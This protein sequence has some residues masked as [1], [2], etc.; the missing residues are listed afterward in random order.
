MSSEMNDPLLEK[1]RGGHDESKE[2]VHGRAAVEQTPEEQ[3][4]L[5]NEEMERF[6]DEE[7]F[8][9]D[10]EAP[11]MT[12]QATETVGNDFII[13]F[14]QSAVPPRLRVHLQRPREVNDH[15]I[16]RHLPEHIASIGAL[17]EPQHGRP[18]S[19]QITF[20]GEIPNQAAAEPGSDACPPAIRGSTSSQPGSACADVAA[21]TS[22]SA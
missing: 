9:E 11:L 18:S 16:L 13:Q 4:D 17:P 21:R 12:L 19:L 20:D 8:M 7:P 3:I 10:V 14:P 6:R 15:I 22:A 5:A 1:R 2:E